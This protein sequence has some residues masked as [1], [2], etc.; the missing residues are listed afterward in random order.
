M[1][2]VS[3]LLVLGVVFAVWHGDQEG[4]FG[5]TWPDLLGGL[6]PHDLKSTA[7]VWIVLAEKAAVVAAGVLWIVR[8]N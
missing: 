1:K 7:L 8:L 5:P 3:V 4:P 6:S 2:T